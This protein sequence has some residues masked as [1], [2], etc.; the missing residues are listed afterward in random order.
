MNLSS[1]FAIITGAS[2]GIGAAYALELAKRGYDLLLVGRDTIRLDRLATDL[3]EKYGVTIDKKCLDLTEREASHTL[4]THTRSLNRPITLLIQNAGFGL[5]GPFIALPQSKIQEMLRLHIHQITESTRLFLPDLRTQ[6]HGA[7]II[8]SSVSG[9]F[10]I[11]YM[12][13][14]AA[15]KAYLNAFGEAVAH[16]LLGTGVTI[17]VCCPGF[18]DTDFH[19]T[20]GY[21]PRHVLPPQ[22]PN[23]VAVVSLDALE[24]RRTLVTIGWQGRLAYWIAHL[25]PHRILLVLAA[26]FVKPPSHSSTTPSLE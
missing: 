24:S 3:H 17:Q 6:G 22:S 14:Y 16:E 8:V 5:Y 10:P 18:T 2:R 9:F 23:Q 11:P 19:E 20:A 12:A 15:T 7:I 21:R 13:E 4:Y 1:P 26:R 25:L